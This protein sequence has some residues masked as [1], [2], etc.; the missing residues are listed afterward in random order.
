MQPVWNRSSRNW[1]AMLFIDIIQLVD[2]F[3]SFD[4]MLMSLAGF[5]LSHVQEQLVCICV[6]LFVR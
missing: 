6:F 4:N 1:Y 3:K 2:W 5:T